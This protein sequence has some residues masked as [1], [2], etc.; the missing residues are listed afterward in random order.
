MD[1][2]EVMFLS[3][4]VYFGIMYARYRNAGARHIHELET[5]T[6]IDNMQTVDDFMRHKKRMRNSRMSGANNEYVSGSTNGGDVLTDLLGK[7]D[8][9]KDLQDTFDF[10][11]ED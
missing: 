1:N 4:I 2:G 10:R 5:E 9:L 3:G 6:D 7:S 8:T 11:D